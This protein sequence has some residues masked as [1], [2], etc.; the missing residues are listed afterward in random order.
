MR[1]PIKEGSSMY[2]V[3][4]TNNSILGGLRWHQAKAMAFAPPAN[5]AGLPIPEISANP[6]SLS[7]I[8]NIKDYVERLIQSSVFPCWCSSAERDLLNWSGSNFRKSLWKSCHRR[9]HWR[10]WAV[11]SWKCLKNQS[12]RRCCT[13]LAW[14]FR[15]HSRSDA[16]ESRA[17]WTESKVYK[18][19]YR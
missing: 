1:L 2:K 4:Q 5:N 10:R 3:L 6:P 9:R 19:S 17:D 14:C 12:W 16:A 11:P 13:S 8:T 7:D 18:F 15:Q